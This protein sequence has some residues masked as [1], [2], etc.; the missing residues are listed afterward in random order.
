MVTNVKIQT[1]GFFSCTKGCS[2]SAEIVPKP[3]SK[4]PSSLFASLKSVA[5]TCYCHR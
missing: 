2:L 4:E 3:G 5:V 1:P